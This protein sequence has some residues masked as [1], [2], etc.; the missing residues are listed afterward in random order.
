MRSAVR[1]A[2]ESRWDLPLR[3][4]SVK[5]T[6]G[7]KRLGKARECPRDEGRYDTMVASAHRDGGGCTLS[8]VYMQWSVMC[9][10]VCVDVSAP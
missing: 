6:L 7:G 2:S 9:R 8:A 1:R 5:V 10:C 3:L 4:V